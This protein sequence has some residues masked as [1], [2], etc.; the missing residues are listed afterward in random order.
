MKHLFK[1][2]A[3]STS[4]VVG[5][6][7]LGDKSFSIAK[8]SG[9]IKGFLNGYEV[10]AISDRDPRL[11]EACVVFASVINNVFKNS[12]EDKI[13]LYKSEW[14]CSKGAS[15]NLLEEVVP[16]LNDCTGK[17]VVVV[18][19]KPEEERDISIKACPGFSVD[20]C[21]SLEDLSKNLNVLKRKI[22]EY[23]EDFDKA[24][25]VAET[26]TR[27]KL[28]G[29][30]WGAKEMQ[31]IL[32]GLR[33]EILSKYWSKAEV[34]AE[35]LDKSL[36][37]LM[38]KLNNGL[39][40]D[41][42]EEKKIAAGILIPN[43]IKSYE[44]IKESSVKLSTLLAPLVVIDKTFSSK[45][46]YPAHFFIP[47]EILEQTKE[48]FDNLISF[49]CLSPTIESKVLYPLDFVRVQM[50]NEIKES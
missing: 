23:S 33:T 27:R 46:S 43:I 22:L 14:K 35:V 20:N 12:G 39:T 40:K 28:K 25:D 29:S 37:R 7:L 19:S 45:T 5:Y 15:V 4:E 24:L 50:L 10:Y 47:A 41:C 49:L 34:G 17:G 26:F 13:R 1:K 21:V 48:S 6:T 9:S 42:D 2:L 30:M 3:A 18:K 8:K 32:D 16:S 31:S 38:H 44:D 11:K 36:V